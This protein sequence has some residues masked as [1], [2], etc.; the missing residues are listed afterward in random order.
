MA[1]TTISS[2][3][4]LI[5]RRRFL[6]SAA[7]GAIVAL[8]PNSEVQ[9]AVISR[10]GRHVR[11]F[12]NFVKYR[13]LKLIADARAAHFAYADRLRERGQLAIGGPLLDEAGRRTGL[14]FIYEAESR[15]DALALAREDPFTLANALASTEINEWRIRGVNVDLLVKANRSGDRVHSEGGTVRLFANYANYGADKAKLDAVRPAHWEYDRRLN[16]N[17]KFVLGGPFANDK[18]GLFVYNAHD[19]KDAIACAEND[20]FFVEGVITEYE[21]REWLIEGVNKDLLRSDFPA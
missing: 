4:Q 8:V 13:D 11:K 20:P 21:L 18:G 10:G 14:L 5:T 15:E 12:I 7:V 9:A 1:E 3:S 6:A 19:R 2:T 16:S 17:G